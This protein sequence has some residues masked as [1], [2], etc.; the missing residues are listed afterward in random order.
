MDFT[1]YYP[2]Y[3]GILRYVYYDIESI[4][5]VY[6]FK[7]DLEESGDFGVFGAFWVQSCTYTL[8]V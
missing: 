5:S 3:I 6:K 7:D 8:D 1:H 2:W 4:Q